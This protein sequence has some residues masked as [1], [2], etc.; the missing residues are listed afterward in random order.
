MGTWCHAGVKLVSFA[1]GPSYDWLTFSIDAE[2]KRSLYCYMLTHHMGCE[3]HFMFILTLLSHS[4]TVLKHKNTRVCRYLGK[5]L[6]SHTCF[7]KNNSTASYSAL[8]NV[9]LV[10]DCLYLLLVCLCDSAHCQFT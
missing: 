9:L 1:S 5:M 10:S 2:V 4:K 7:Y 6:S 3:C 8:K